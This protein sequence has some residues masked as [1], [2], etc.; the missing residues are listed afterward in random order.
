MSPSKSCQILDLPFELRTEILSHLLPDLRVLT[1]EPGYSTTNDEP[2]R[3]NSP[4]T[5]T[6][7]T[8]PSNLQQLR[9]DNAKCRLS[10]LSASKQ[11]HEDGVDFLYRRKTYVAQ[12]Y[13]FGI[14]FLF[15]AGDLRT[16]PSMP[17]HEMKEF[18]IQI[19]SCDLAET[20]CRLR[21][22]L[23]WFCSLL[24]RNT[25]KMRKIRIEFLYDPFWEFAWDQPN[26]GD[27]AVEPLVDVLADNSCNANLNAWQAGFNSTFAYILSALVHLPIASECTIEIPDP[28]RGKK[29][30]IETASM[31]ERAVQG[32][33]PALRDCIPE[34]VLEADRKAFDFKMQH[35]DGPSSDCQ[36]SGCAEH[37]QKSH[38]QFF[39]RQA[40]V[41]RAKENAWRESQ[42]VPPVFSFW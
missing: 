31:Y 42:A 25:V 35:P 39:E 28:L 8:E 9:V 5:W 37:F 1:C 19:A 12:V 23:V 24:R 17:Y 34:A 2:P 20:G 26:T 27:V 36:C 21:D 18:V 10:I 15:N 33:Y 16:L 38:R 6:F 41:G 3:Y 29:H 22:N 11:L 40:R 30:L 14:D 7:P 13:N 4:Q 32:T